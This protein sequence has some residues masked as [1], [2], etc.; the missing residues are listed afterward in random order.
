MKTQN[1][2][3]HPFW[4]G[5][6]VGSLVGTGLMYLVGTQ[7]GRNT[8]QKIL[9]NTDNFETAVHEILNFLR[10]NNLTQLADTELDKKNHDESLPP[11][12]KPRD[13]AIDTLMEKVD[14]AAK[15]T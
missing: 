12:Q 10:N 11:L 8:A 13:E 4:S 5:F 14:S 9:E 2:E 7:K 1:E 6:V 15:H 3:N